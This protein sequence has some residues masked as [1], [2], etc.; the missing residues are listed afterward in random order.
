MLKDE[1]YTS[2]KHYS[3][4]LTK[5]NISNKPKATAQLRP[6]FKHYLA[7]QTVSRLYPYPF[8]PIW[9]NFSYILQLKSIP[10]LEQSPNI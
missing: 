2:E 4:M 3:I 7:L 6:D 10:I 5:D 9:T 8:Y 1:K